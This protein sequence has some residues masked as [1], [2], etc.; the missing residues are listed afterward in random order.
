M[1]RQ[2]AI[3]IETA[4][5]QTELEFSRLELFNDEKI[6]VSSTIQ[7]ISDISKIFT[8]YSQGFT[9]PCSPTNNAIF[10][11][12]YQNDVNATIDYQKRYNAYIEV[13][14]VLFRRGKIQL[15]KTNL[16]NGSADSYSVTFYGA[17]VSLK[18][19]FNEDKL[20][21]LDHTSLNH[22][23]INQEVYDRVTIDSSVTDYD[24]RYPLI[25]SKRI[26]QFSGSVPL[27]QDNCPEWFLYPTN[28]SDN[29]G[30]NAGEI[31]YQELFPAVRVASIFD[32]IEAEY[33][34]TFNG[35]FL[36]SDMFRKAFLYYKNK[37]K[38]NFVT[39]PKNVTFTVTGSSIVETFPSSTPAAT[40]PVPSPYTSF[41]LTNNTFNTIYVTPNLGG[42]SPQTYGTVSHELQITYTGS[43]PLLSNCWLDVY[44]NN[45]YV[46]TFT[47]ISNLGGVFTL[48]NLEQTPNNDVFYTFKLRGAL[49]QTLTF[50]FVYTLQYNYW[51]QDAFSNYQWFTY[52]AVTSFNTNNVT[53]TS[54]T[55]L[56]GLAPDM[57]ISDFITGICNEFNMTVYSKTKNVF[58]FEPI[59]DWYKKGAVIDITKFTD[60]TS[61]EIERLKLYKLIEFK[62]QDSESFINKYFLESPAN[63]TAHGYGNTKENYPFDGGEYK[64]QSPFENLLHTN[65]G[66]NLQVGY[67]LNKDFAPY[68]PKPVLLYM[69]TLT[70]LTAG[71]KIHWHGLPNT[72][73]YV[74]F[75]QDSEILIQGGIFPLTL[76]FG[77]EISSFY[78]VENPNTLYSLYY[79]S[80][81][82]NLYNPK[83]RLVKVK[84]I[85]PVSLLTQLQLNDRLIIR[86]KRY[87]INEMQSDLTTGDVDFTLI[88]DFAEVNPIVYGVSTPS[89]SVHSM[90]ILFSNGATQVRVSKSANASNVTLS[91]VLFSSEGYLKITIPAN[92][93]RTITITLDSDFSN[94]NTETNYII[95][96]Q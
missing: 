40:T 70:T 41:N 35:L 29:I 43:L 96:E 47:L 8:D 51:A 9:I 17:G 64:I 37:E 73:Q 26:W 38:F 77:V 14:T 95:I 85:L 46:Q 34:I 30:D 18:D 36:T 65:F 33:G 54:F 78:N 4:L 83:N 15:E 61:I 27:P 25:S 20:S 67:C 89:G 90:A 7:N 22:N 44:K 48:P 23:Y 39:Q 82:T 49:A 62:Y 93:T 79:Q 6:S 5:A 71:D 68:I 81:L 87:L 21:Q 32:L 88:N 50:S 86:D 3:F 57:K 66:N 80:Y 94:G 2:V 69:N 59:Q 12:F 24:V 11:H 13:D 60:V 16:K 31:E 19:Y 75:G 10:Q 91:S 45:V 42:A 1:K 56:Q 74:P 58:T 28:N 63:L 72:A 52:K 76:N 84:T 53:L 55:D 92:A